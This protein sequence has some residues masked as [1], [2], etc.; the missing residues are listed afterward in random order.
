MESFFN[1]SIYC[2]HFYQG[3]NKEIF[4]YTKSVS[5]Y[6]D[7]DWLKNLDQELAFT[8]KFVP[9]PIL[10]KF[11]R[12]N[13]S[14]FSYK[15]FISS[16]ETCISHRPC[17][18]RLAVSTEMLSQDSSS[19][20]LSWEKWCTRMIPLCF[21]SSDREA[22]RHKKASNMK[23]NTL[24]HLFSFTAQSYRSSVTFTVSFNSSILL[25]LFLSPPNIFDEV[26]ASFST[27]EFIEDILVKRVWTLYC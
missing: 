14:F 10:P 17:S 15:M 18:T 13:S 19:I 9:N 20:D 23:H 11:G 7:W 4:F 6:K 22:K 2:D 24:M 5:S 27:R 21:S 25:F 12:G 1:Q 8:S 26:A 3:P 16:K